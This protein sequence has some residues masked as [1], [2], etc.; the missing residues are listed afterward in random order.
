[1]VTICIATLFFL[2]LQVRESTLLQSGSREITITETRQPSG[3]SASFS[4]TWCAVTYLS[5]RTRRSATRDCVSA[6]AF[7]QVRE[8]SPFAEFEAD[9]DS[10]HRLQ[11]ART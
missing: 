3:A 5:K 10:I 7:H 2:F 4:L 6:N 8:E 9:F 1:M 11:S